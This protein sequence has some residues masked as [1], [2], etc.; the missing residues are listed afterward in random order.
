MR[1]ILRNRLFNLRITNM[2][3]AVSLG[4][5]L[6]HS[7][8]KL[9][10]KS[11]TTST[12]IIGSAE[13]FPTVVRDWI[14][15][16]NEETARKAEVDTVQVNGK[17]YFVGV[18]AQRQSQA[19][20]FSGQSRNWIETEQHDALL[21]SAWNR[22]NSVLERNDIVDPERITLVL[23]LPASYYADQRETL[24]TRANA[25][26]QRLVKPHQELQ[27]Y[28]ESQSRAPLLCV[29]FDSN[30][31]ETGHGGDDQTWGVVEIGQFT[32]DF[33]L[34]DRG[35]EVDSAASSARGAHM[36]YDRIAAAFKQKGYEAN[37]ELISNAIKTRKVKDFGKDVDVGDIVAPAISE[38]STYIQ[39]EVASRFG[40]KARSM[41]GIIVAGG[42]AYMVGAEIKAKYP[43]AVIP[44]NPRFAVAEGY[45]RF[46]LLT[47]I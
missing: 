16:A 37:F 1:Y 41:D 47:L 21:V 40:S 12:P 20:T 38:F 23:G 22:A 43:N 42:G 39:D 26:L 25:L 18:T 31:A 14:Q 2:K 34:H 5:D 45:S 4:F 46:G 33:T 11:T 13:I 27:I 28:I 36:V 35:Q 29:I 3:H 9:S 19:E 8:V 17:K 44:T 15:I 24:R 6:G 10:I 7:S 30:G 32:T